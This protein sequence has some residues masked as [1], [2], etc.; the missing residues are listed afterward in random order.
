MGFGNDGFNSRSERRL[1]SQT[2][3]HVSFYA[4]RTSA[5]I[6]RPILKLI[7]PRT[8]VKLVLA[9]SQ[10]HLEVTPMIFLKFSLEVKALF[11]VF[12]NRG[13]ENVEA[14]GRFTQAKS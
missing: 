5:A 7:W 13:D 11:V 8:P 6:N 3:E 14:L 10:F 2:A 4:S 12:I 9:S 1:P